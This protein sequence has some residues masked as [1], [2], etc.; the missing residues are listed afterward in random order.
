MDSYVSVSECRNRTFEHVA[1]L[2]ATCLDGDRARERFRFAVALAIPDASVRSR[3]PHMLGPRIG[4]RTI[5]R[6]EK[7]LVPSKDHTC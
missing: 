3:S 5:A 7:R 1:N 4:A 6:L 2:C